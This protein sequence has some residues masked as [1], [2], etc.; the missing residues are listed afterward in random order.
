[1]PYLS[2]GRLGATSTAAVVPVGAVGAAASSSDTVETT[3]GVVVVGREHDILD[4]RLGVVADELGAEH[5][6]SSVSSVVPDADS[7]ARVTVASPDVGS[8]P[9]FTD[10]ESS[11][12]PAIGL[13]ASTADG[14]I[15]RDGEGLRLTDGATSA[16]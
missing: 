1:M 5:S 15:D 3:T 2:C 8:T 7:I 9:R 6:V 16:L 11:V 13:G 14:E 10:T 4:G 12:D